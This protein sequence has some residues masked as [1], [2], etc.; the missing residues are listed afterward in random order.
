MYYLVLPWGKNFGWGVCGKH[1]TRELAK[2]AEVRLLTQRLDRDAAD[3]EIEL[4]FFQDKVIAGDEV[5]FLRQHNRQHPVL[6]GISDHQL[7][8]YYM[9][10]SA[11]HKVGYTF[12]EA[13]VA[14]ASVQKAAAYFDVVATGCDWCTGVLRDKGLRQAVT[15]VQGIDPL[16]FH[17]AF[18]EKELFKDR[19]VVFSGGKFEF[20]KGQDIVIR[21]YKALQ[22][23]HA[24]VM[25]VNSWYNIW[26]F[27][28]ATMT[29]SP[30]IQFTMRQGDYVTN[31][32]DLLHQQGLDMKRV[33]T[34]PLYPNEIVARTY[35]NTD[36]GLFPN[37]CEGGTNLVMMEYMA[38]GKPVIGSFNT[39][40]KDILTEENARLVQ[41]MRSVTVM[42]QEKPY[43]VWDDPDLDETIAH[44]EWAYQHRDEL[45]QMGQQAG[46]DLAR[47][48]WG[49]A[50][51]QFHRLLSGENGM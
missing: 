14:D 11:P 37:R 13:L 36:V 23:K 26:D 25:L 21:A 12:F 3:H 47:F 49:R 24:D 10:V 38:C 17:P 8:P 6:Q 51:R 43:A 18:S 46:R 29:M 32:N 20:R 41:S 7:E 19:F 35:Q 40:H 48:T 34:L 4:R 28:M 44:L 31:M 30:L 16:T 22:D 9:P 5:E 45:R 42:A 2:L 39:G 15:V 27:A 1:L 50:A 33:V